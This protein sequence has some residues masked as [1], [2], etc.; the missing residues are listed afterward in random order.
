[1]SRMHGD[2]PPL[3]NTPSWRGTQLNKETQGQ[4]Y[5]YLKLWRFLAVTR[6][7]VAAAMETVS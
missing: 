7:V 6:R 3:P 4:L 5:I 1:M 2:I